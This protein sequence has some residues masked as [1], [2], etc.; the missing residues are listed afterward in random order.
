MKMADIYFYH[1]ED[2]DEDSESAFND[3]DG[4]TNPD[5]DL[6][7]V[8]K[9]EKYASSENI[10]NRQM[11]ARTLLDTLR[12][13]TEDAED[14]AAILAIINRLAQ[15][16]EPS[17]RAELMEQVPHI[18]M[19]C[20]E[21]PEKLS[22]VVP[23]HL[24]PLVVKFLTDTNN[25]VRKTSQAALLVLLEQGLVE[26]MDVEEQVC[27]V[28][29]RLTESDS[30]DDYRTEAV[31]LL[32]KMAPLI[33]K[34][35]S[36]RLFLER[37]ASLCVDPLFHVRKV[38]AANFGDFSGVVGS[39]PTEQVLLPKFFYL[40]ED[41]VWGVRKAC[42][43]V[44]MPVS[45]V[46]SPSVRQSE[47]SPLFVNLLRDQSRW[48]RM[49]A[50]QALGPFISTFADPAI[51][52]LL[53]NENGE[54]VISD[55]DQL[56]DRLDKL[57]TDRGQ[58]IQE[59]SRVNNNPTSE[60]VDNASSSQDANGNNADDANIVNNNVAMD[61]EDDKNCWAVELV[62]TSNISPEERRAE[63]Y[64][65]DQGEVVNSDQERVEDTF[66]SFLYWREPVP[67]LELVDVDM[68]DDAETELDD[69]D[70]VRDHLTQLDTESSTESEREEIEKVDEDAEAALENGLNSLEEEDRP[71]VDDR[72]SGVAKEKE[73]TGEELE[74][75][76]QCLVSTLKGPSEDE[77]VLEGTEDEVEKQPTSNWK[78]L[79]DNVNGHSL[80]SSVG[81]M[82]EIGLPD[83]TS[84][85]K[86]GGRAEKGEGSSH[87]DMELESSDNL[88]RSLP[89]ITFQKFDDITGGSHDN[90]SMELY[91][92]GDQDTS[93]SSISTFDPFSNQSLHS[94]PPSLESVARTAADLH[95]PDPALPKG[96]P[97][98]DQSIVP[99]LLIDHY[100]SMIDPSRA[101]TVDNDI[102]R[103]CAFSLPAVALTLGRSNWPLLRETY[104]TLASDMQWKVRR[105]L[106][107]SIH[108]L[109]VILGEEAA[110]NDLVPIFNGFIK[111]LDEV[112][113]GILKHLADFLKLLRE[114][115]RAEYLPKI[116]EFLKTDNERNWRFRLELCEQVGLLVPLFPPKS[117]REY[118]A[119]IALILVQDKV[120]AVRQSAAQVLSVTVRRLNSSDDPDLAKSLVADL[121]EKL[122]HSS[123]W[124]RRQTF[125]TVCGEL[126][127]VMPV[128]QFS[129]E[130]LPHLLDLT[131][132]NVPNVRYQVAQILGIGL[133][134]DY[135]EN[136]S[137]NK[138]LLVQALTQLLEDK[139]L[140]VRQMAATGDRVKKS[141]P[142][143]PPPPPEMTV[144]D[145]DIT[146]SSSGS[147]GQTQTV[148]DNF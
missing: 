95:P 122:A 69:L 29:I 68:E 81:D 71:L 107:S 143:P 87:S 72:P 26:R 40:C 38:C 90:S 32:S 20:Q 79:D 109:G 148:V 85:S 112:R 56:A 57:E 15:D 146:S 93:T 49:A 86:T 78:T 123:H 44:F 96:P 140:D 30:L 97:E 83:R 12:Q 133:P 142:Q 52:A 129:Q 4:S 17:V 94:S 141:P 74:V 104:E 9:L 75:L 22:H 99:Q 111:D 135:F 102:A 73:T 19:Y 65:K 61:L 45:C 58:R 53:H 110:A 105:T 128:T 82:N 35:M 127:A 147:D 121:A 101:Q 11:V 33:G 5:D 16:I 115:D 138:E 39:D 114:E 37:F 28:I 145:L 43:D 10:F 60:T 67:D 131:W 134:Q 14:V 13:V 132:D 108:E 6:A 59:S 113:I 124:I 24:L 54:I 63:E 88:W 136:E 106:A 130:L 23:N 89:V 2:A 55:P 77:A 91:H 117:V 41:G 8:A 119:P 70:V 64:Y 144:H 25:Q 62:T 21:L 50:F 120:S 84:V 36:E 137:P 98:T 51:T 103:H 27:P 48:V 34:E 66:T 31:A 7:P 42:A 18:A 47:L 76:E 139:D 3:S 125:C 80:L 118:L 126:V 100:V 92:P 116:G 1:H 46:C